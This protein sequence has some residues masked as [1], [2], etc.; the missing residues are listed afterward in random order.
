MSIVEDTLWKGGIEA[1]LKHS[2]RSLIWTLQ[3][4]TA[5]DYRDTLL[6]EMNNVDVK[7]R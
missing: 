4:I 1:S 7:N 3:E 2:K 6:T 5:R